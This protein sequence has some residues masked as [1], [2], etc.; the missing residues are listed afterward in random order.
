M[1]TKTAGRI[2]RA[3]STMH[4]KANIVKIEDY[5][6]SVDVSHLAAYND[7]LVFDGLAILICERGT[8]AVR[9]GSI[10]Y[11]LTANRILIV[12]PY[13]IIRFI[14]CDG[15]TS[16]F[17]LG[18]DYYMSHN[19]SGADY[20]VIARLINHPVASSDDVEM[21]RLIDLRTVIIERLDNVDHPY[22]KS[23][24]RVLIFAFLAEI[25]CLY[26]KNGSTGREIYA[27]HSERIS[28]QFFNILVENYAQ[29]RS[30]TYYADK[31]CL[32]PKYLSTVIKRVTGHPIT[33]WINE[34][35]VNR[36][37]SLLKSTDMS[38]LQI[39]EELNFS[40][41]SFFGKYFKQYVGMTP[42][43]YRLGKTV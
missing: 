30:A 4:G 7:G 27:T 13:R 9:V 5:K 20:E 26:E 2:V 12:M 36:A 39:S 38:V 19:I 33:E 17:F 18:M 43:G 22:S 14:S 28:D 32:T 21:R 1:S 11:N 3:S 16:G 35:V 29:Q 15:L 6:F 8:C 40:N 25:K 34:M 23:C 24:V 31:L 37:K 41:P 10:E 42:L